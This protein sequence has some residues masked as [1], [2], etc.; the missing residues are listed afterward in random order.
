M[1]D[2]KIKHVFRPPI[3]ARCVGCRTV[4]DLEGTEVTVSPLVG[5]SCPRCKKTMPCSEILLTWEA[6]SERREDDE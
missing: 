6:V 2:K 3:R 5:V 4:V 1:T